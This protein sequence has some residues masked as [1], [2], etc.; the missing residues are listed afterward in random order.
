MEGISVVVVPG[1]LANANDYAALAKELE[2]RGARVEV[3]PWSAND[4][5][6]TLVGGDF[7]RLLDKLDACARALREEEEE[8]GKLVVVAHSAGGW[9]SRLWLGADVAY[10][11]REP[12]RGRDIARVLVTLGTPHASKEAY[13]FGRA[14]ERRGGESGRAMSLSDAARGSSLALTNEIYPGAHERDVKY[15][16]VTGALDFVGSDAFDFAGVVRKACRRFIDGD[17]GDAW[18]DGTKDI[19]DAWRAYLAGVS[20]KANTGGDARVV[21]DGICPASVAELDG[22]EIVRVACHHSPNARCDWYGSPA[23]VDAWVPYIL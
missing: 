3:A 1:F 23:I 11:G 12:Y 18:R 10:C 4:W 6:P 19:A 22:A 16:A 2:K 20:Y 14:R 8:G 21:G 9:L 15:V 17:G 5:L 7:V 13:P